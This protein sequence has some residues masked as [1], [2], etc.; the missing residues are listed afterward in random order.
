ML[1]TGSLWAF[2]LFDVAEEI[3]LAPLRMRQAESPAGRE[4]KFRHPAPEYVRFESPP[5]IERRSEVSLSTGERCAVRVKY[6]Q[7]GV[8]SVAIEIPF[9][10]GWEELIQQVHRL[11]E[12]PEVEQVATRIARECAGAAGT[13]LI[14]PYEKWLSEDYLVVQIHSTALPAAGLMAA[15]PAE[16]CQLVRAEDQPL[17]ESEVRDIL[18]SSVSYYPTDL[19][20]AG[21]TA[22]VLYDSPDAAYSTLQ[23]LEHANTQLLEF[24]HYDDVLRGLSADLYK[25]LEQKPGP[26]RRWRMAKE[27]A[28]LNTLRLDVQELADRSENAI[29]FLSDMFYAR[30]YRLAAGKIGVEDYRASVGEKLRIAQEL[31]H[32]I[33]E[34]FHQSRAFVLEMVVIVILIIDLIF[35]FRGKV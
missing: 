9:S 15:H 12:Q 14:K 29:R 10:S 27:A 25:T 19:L 22:A 11:V 17:S 16:L 33:I 21:W 34:E 3:N 31:Y 7:Y 32:F 13:A 8:I 30:V 28:R 1:L 35:L 18:G 23:L 5:A 6:F 20:I 4:P 2:E 26:I 24:R